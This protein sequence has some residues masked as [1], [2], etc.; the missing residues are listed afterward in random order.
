MPHHHDEVFLG[1]LPARTN[2]VSEERS[3]AGLASPLASCGNVGASRARGY[4]HAVTKKY[5]KFHIIVAEGLR[6]EF[7]NM[8]QS[9]LDVPTR[10][11]FHKIPF[12]G[13]YKKAH[14]IEGY[15]YTITRPELTSGYR[16]VDDN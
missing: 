12:L 4:A 11:S 6:C 7:G 14:I 8:W 3:A 10:K 9:T 15:F 1:A 5:L 2:E 13:R 16:L